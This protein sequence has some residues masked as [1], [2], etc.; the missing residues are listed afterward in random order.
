MLTS[1]LGSK[2][3]LLFVVKKTVLLKVKP[4]KHREFDGKIQLFLFIFSES[5]SINGCE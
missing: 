3:E 4:T 1:P 2:K 5:S